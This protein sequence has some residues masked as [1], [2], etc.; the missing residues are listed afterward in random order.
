M[1]IDRDRSRYR[2]AS[3]QI[4]HLKTNVRSVW[5]N[6]CSENV[7]EYLEL[8]SIGPLGCCRNYGYLGPLHLL[9]L[10]HWCKQGRSKPESLTVK[11][12]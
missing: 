1:R 10:T 8:P 9:R 5:N 2:S 11:Q 12:S 7:E 4:K 6:G 3:W